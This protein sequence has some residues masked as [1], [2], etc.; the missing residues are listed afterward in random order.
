MPV[1]MFAC[2]L[3]HQALFAR[4][5]HREA[6]LEGAAEAHGHPGGSLG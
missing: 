2:C 5:R 3:C 4:G 1:V 6:D